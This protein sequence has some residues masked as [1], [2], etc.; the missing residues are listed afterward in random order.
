M[1]VYMCAQQGYVFGCIGLCMYVYDCLKSGVFYY[2]LTEFKCLK[3]GLLRSTKFTDL[4]IHDSPNKMRRSPQ[5]RNIL[6]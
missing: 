2:L 1:C 4:A 6:S 5:P 3:C